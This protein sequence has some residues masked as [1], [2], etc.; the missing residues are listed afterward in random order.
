MNPDDYARRCMKRLVAG[1]MTEKRRYERLIH[2]LST[3][4]ADDPRR[5][6]V[7]ELLQLA[8]ERRDRANP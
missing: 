8:R 5:Q 6:R 2:F 7:E 4:P 1:R 3:T